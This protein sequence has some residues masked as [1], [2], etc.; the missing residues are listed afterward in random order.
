[1]KHTL[2]AN[3]LLTMLLLLVG[4]LSGCRDIE[5]KM[6]PTITMEKTY[7]IK[8]DRKLLIT[9]EV[10]N[11]NIN[12]IYS[13][14]L[15]GRVISTEK[16]LEYSFPITGD[17]TIKYS[18]STA[19]GT[20]WQEIVVKVIDLELPI[21]GMKEGND[22]LAETGELL[23]LTPEIAN[24]ENIKYTWELDG[25]AVSSEPVFEFRPDKEGVHFVH[26][27]T[28]NDDGEDD[29]LVKVVVVP[30]IPLEISFPYPQ[31]SGTVGRPFR[32]E[33][34]IT[35]TKN[36]SYEWSV[37]GQ[38][39]EDQTGPILVY[40]PTRVGA[41]Q[42]KVCAYK[43]DPS[44]AKKERAGESIIPVQ[45]GEP[46]AHFR[47][48]NPAKS[49]KYGGKVYEFLAAPGQFVNEGYSAH[50]MD[51]AIKYA[52]ERLSQDVYVS[53]GGFGGYLVIGFDHSIPNTGAFKGY[54]FAV[55]GNSFKGSSEPGIVWVMQD[56][57][58]NGLPDDNW[59]ELRGSE[60]GKEGT[61]QD[62]EVTY[63]RPATARS[64][65]LWADNMGNTGEI[66]WLNFHQQDSY[67]PIW[68]KPNRYVLRGTRLKSANFDQ[69]G[70]GT[71]WIN[72]EYEWG[73][74]DNFSPI[75]R[76]TDDIN[77][78]AAPNANH[79]RIKDAM[80]SNGKPIHLEYIDF[81]KVVTG[82]NTKSGWLGE[83]STECFKFIDIQVP[84]SK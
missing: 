38:V 79:F 36:I 61:I 59:Y 31:H 16:N 70:Q 44:G 80:D 58:G 21:I 10:S 71:Y 30:S 76:L 83:V 46:D 78:G 22:I 24:T 3:L 28:Q 72:P 67:Y 62:Y 51:D 23:K 34:R 47:S 33:P 63:F 40:T 53:L 77:Y 55:M 75:D 54:D 39:I 29:Y 5:S 68:V 49:S 15:D 57:N 50:T 4:G 52:E 2:Q 42:V 65:V 43:T 84:S 13:W 17:Y 41:L 8:P 7:T 64:N 25:K 32:I 37:D 12:T 18:V 20:A 19:D 74:V 56:E 73:Y 27:F 45:V 26:L 1:M 14:K 82:L 48:F 69:S 9:P 81:V 66:D 11:D 6:P 60:T 35:T